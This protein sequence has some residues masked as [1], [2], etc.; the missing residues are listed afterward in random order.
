MQIPELILK[1]VGTGKP[2]LFLHGFLE[3]HRIWNAIYPSFVNQGFQCVLV[4]LPCHGASRFE[5]ENCGMQLMASAVNEALLRSHIDPVF[6]FGHSMGG[7]VALELLRIRNF[8]LTLVHSNFWADPETKK[9]DRNR[10]IEVVKTN[11]TLF[12]QESIP[13]LFAPFNRDILRGEIQFLIDQAAKLPASE[14]AAATAGLRDRRASH[15]L[16]NTHRIAIVQGMLDPI[17]PVGI[18]EAE[19]GKLDRKP[20]I[21]QLE[22]SGHMGFFEQPAELIKCLEQILFR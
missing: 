14:I 21:L 20:R 3:D 10:V 15:D 1:V 2:I 4:D 17:I 16:M 6:V 9:Q 7:Y 22:N 12:L 11:K 13:N 5:G 8:S 19:C 18:M